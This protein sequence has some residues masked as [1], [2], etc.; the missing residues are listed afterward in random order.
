MNVKV[1][2]AKGNMHTQ[3]ETYIKRLLKKNQYQ[4][5]SA[6]EILGKFNKYHLARFVNFYVLLAQKFGVK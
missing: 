6:F 4:F 3:I 5:P 2:L 1:K